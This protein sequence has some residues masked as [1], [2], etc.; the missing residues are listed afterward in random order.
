MFA[1][2]ME[3]DTMLFG[4]LFLQLSLGCLFTVVA[5]CEAIDVVMG[6]L[7]IVDHLDGTA[8]G[9]VAVA[10]FNADGDTRVASHVALFEATSF[11]IHHDGISFE[12]VPHGGQLGSAVFVDGS[13][14]GKT[15]FLQKGTSV[16]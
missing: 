14:D 8:N 2:E 15:T 10:V 4:E 12:E 11:G 3:G 1:F 5:H 16:L 7:L 13:E 9:D 6:D